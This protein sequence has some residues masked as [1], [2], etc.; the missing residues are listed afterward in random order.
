M[1]RRMSMS[2]V[3]SKASYLSTTAITGNAITAATAWLRQYASGG[4]RTAN[5]TETHISLTLSKGRIEPMSSTWSQ[6]PGM[7]GFNI[8][9]VYDGSHDPLIIDTTAAIS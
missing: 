2:F 7:Q 4:T 3:T 9:A 5:A 8:I 1:G 6:A